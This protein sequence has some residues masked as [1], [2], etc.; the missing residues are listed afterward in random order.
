MTL[1]WNGTRKRE[2]CEWWLSYIENEAD[3]YLSSQG[4]IHNTLPY[5]YTSEPPHD[6][7]G[8]KAN[9][10]LLPK[11]VK[12]ACESTVK[13]VDRLMNEVYIVLDQ[14]IDEI[15]MTLQFLKCENESESDVVDVEERV[16]SLEKDLKYLLKM[17]EM[18]EE[19][20]QRSKSGSL[21]ETK[22]I[23]MTDI[24]PVGGLI[25][26]RFHIL[27]CELR[28]AM[29]L[30]GRRTRNLRLKKVREPDNGNGHRSA[31]KFAEFT[32]KEN[33]ATETPQ[34]ELSE[35]VFATSPMYT[36]HGCLTVALR[37]RTRLGVGR[38]E[39]NVAEKNEKNESKSDLGDDKEEKRN[40]PQ[41]EL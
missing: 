3:T 29:E 31:I 37:M 7:D 28:T 10:L 14:L 22:A 21:A 17:K 6:L 13:L 39:W 1:I 9:L 33:V 20:R 4:Y 25:M 30:W 35:F 12:G 5:H 19:I 38:I 40:E 26:A 34:S 16:S 11:L 2:V 8:V 27:E 41:N 24:V 18:D 32:G 23:E 36:S 15:Q